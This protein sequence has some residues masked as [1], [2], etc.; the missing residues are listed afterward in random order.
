MNTNTLQ[1]PLPTNLK[2]GQKLDRAE[3]SLVDTS[4]L[5]AGSSAEVLAQSANGAIIKYT[6]IGLD[7]QLLGNCPG[8][9]HGTV[10]TSFVVTGG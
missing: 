3:A 5:K 6:L 10:V 1:V 9:G 7:R 4:N 2:P 8:G